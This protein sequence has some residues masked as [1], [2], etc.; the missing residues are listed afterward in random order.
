MLAENKPTE[1]RRIFKTIEN[2]VTGN[3]HYPK[4]IYQ[5][6]MLSDT[7]EAQWLYSHK[8]LQAARKQ[9]E[10]RPQV[11]DIYTNLAAIERKKSGPA[12]AIQLLER[13]LSQ[14]LHRVAERTIRC[15]LEPLKRIHSPLPQLDA[16]LWLNAKSIESR[17]LKGKTILL[18]FWSPGCRPCLRL[19][20]RLQNIHI[21]YR[22]SNFLLIGVTRLTGRYSDDR[23]HKISVS[24]PREIELI[25]NLLAR[26]GATF[27]VA[28][29]ETADIFNQLGILGT[30]TIFLIDR[31]GYA[32]DFFL[33]GEKLDQMAAVIKKRVSKEAPH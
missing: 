23:H 6:S 14:P 21:E 26:H 32:Q 33:G 13:A 24:R 3:K 18:Y 22:D 12:K 8:F 31:S 4:I 15:Y 28:L 30:P 19:M 16:D 17:N 2:Q 20:P 10:L 9:E 1:A 27:P 7:V 25:E 29:T 5:L 11:G